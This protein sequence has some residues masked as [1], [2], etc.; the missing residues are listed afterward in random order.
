MA[1]TCTCYKEGIPYS[2]SCPCPEGKDGATSYTEKALTAAREEKAATDKRTKEYE[3][4]VK[5]IKELSDK[6]TDKEIDYIKTIYDA[7]PDGIPEDILKTLQDRYG[8]EVISKM[9][10]VFST[11]TLIS[12]QTP[13]SSFT[14]S[15][16]KT[17]FSKEVSTNPSIPST[18]DLVPGAWGVSYVRCNGVF[19]IGGYP[20]GG[21]QCC[22]AESVSFGNDYTAYSEFLAS[23][24]GIIWI[25]DS[26]APE[27]F[28]P[29]PS[30]IPS[31][32]LSGAIS[33]CAGLCCSPQVDDCADLE[34]TL[35]FAQNES[36]NSLGV[37]QADAI[38]SV[39]ITWLSYPNAIIDVQLLDSTNGTVLETIPD[40]QL[41]ATDLQFTGLAQGIYEITPPLNF[42]IPTG[43]ITDPY[44]EIW[45]CNS[46]LTYT[47]VKDNVQPVPGC[48]DPNACNYNPEATVDNNSCLY[49]DCAGI[50]GGE[51]Y[52]DNCDNCVGGTQNPGNLPCEQDCAGV[53]GGLLQ[54]DECGECH[55]PLGDLYNQSCTDCTGTI[56]GPHLIDICGNCTDPNNPTLWN[57]ECTGCL[58]KCAINYDPNV[59]QGCVDCCLHLDFKVNCTCCDSTSTP[60]I[61]LYLFH[62][63]GGTNT[64]T[65][66]TI[67][68]GDTI[69][70]IPDGSTYITDQ[71]SDGQYY[72]HLT[73]DLG[74]AGSEVVDGIYTLQY[75]SLIATGGDG[76][77]LT[78][79]TGIQIKKCDMV[80]CS[81]EGSLQKYMKDIILANKCCDCDAL[82]DTYYKAWTLYR[83]L[84]ITSTCG[85]DNYVDDTIKKINALIK[86]MKNGICNK[87]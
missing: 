79:S 6:I 47:I 45:N 43:I 9:I 86:E 12:I 58:D 30:G 22:V 63:Q 5:E 10:S 40:V 84:K 67:T 4:G 68:Y 31:T 81:I 39:N 29:P 57:A 33:V 18:R 17:Y 72:S 15:N 66:G 71:T 51:A 37:G 36:V 78:P 35:A 32:T 3:E 53:W 11:T 50:C 56:N 82:S 2:C 60:S 21:H 73:V 62:P 26:T 65:G 42:T 83:A 61:T 16:G 87:C 19:T 14:A 27:G 75:D 85:I 7:Y 1:C 24:I 44:I 64:L 13:T 23:W 59:I 20:L 25:Y 38:I 34:I 76:N 70:T 55:D 49:D 8:K 46:Q 52:L 74:T 54:I 48:M 69:V 77:F 80:L 41:P 28:L